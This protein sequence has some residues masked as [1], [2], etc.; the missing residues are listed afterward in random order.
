MPT[1]KGI[2]KGL[3]FKL[4]KKH[5]AGA[6]ADSAIRAALKFNESNIHTTLT[7]LNERPKNTMQAR[8]NINAYLQLMRQISRLHA[9]SDISVRSSQLGYGTGELLTNGVRELLKM[10]EQEKITVWLE[11]QNQ[12]E[13]EHALSLAK[14]SRSKFLGVE[15]PASEISSGKFYEG[16][17]KIGTP[18]KISTYPFEG[19]KQES[20]KGLSSSKP[21]DKAKK[22]VEDCPSFDKILKIVPGKVLYL[23]SSDDK[24]AYKIKKSPRT[25]KKELVLEVLFGYSSKRIKKLVKD[26]INVSIYIPYGRDWVPYAIN[27]L[28]EGHIRD[29]AV[30][31]LD[32]E[33]KAERIRDA[34]G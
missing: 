33:K 27:R 21:N 25:N 12:S 34:N 31:I 6:T 30:A 9:N 14:S 8:Y 17:K 29:I 15:I 28:T 22:P 3:I 24:I 5:I 7:F 26:N 4:V 10:A 1:E 18:I 11:C 19:V 23:S 32:G 16:F 20:Q 2:L 13:L